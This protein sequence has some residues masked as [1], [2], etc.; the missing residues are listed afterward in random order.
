MALTSAG[1]ELNVTIIDNTANTST[2]RYALNAIDMTQAALD[3]AEIMTALNGVTAGVI[4][5]Y[6]IAERFIEDT[7]VLPASGVEVEERAVVTVQLASS[8]VKRATLVIPAPEVG[9]FVATSGEQAAEVDTTNAQL[10][11]Y[12]QLFQAT[13]GVATLS[14][15]ETVSELGSNYIIRGKK[16]H[17]ASSRG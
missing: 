12:V 13:G 14:D 1:F 17:R 7:L 10:I 16:T 4:K 8:P 2:L 15:G 6:S 5:S 11:D 3:A 9:L